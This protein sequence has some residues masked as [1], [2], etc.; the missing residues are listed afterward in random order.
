MVRLH[1]WAQERPFFMRH[2]GIGC[3][4]HRITNIISR[5]HTLT[6]AENRG[7]WEDLQPEVLDHGQMR[8]AGSLRLLNSQVMY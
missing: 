6:I 1:M 2:S 7:M 3:H 8:S 4:A 5:L